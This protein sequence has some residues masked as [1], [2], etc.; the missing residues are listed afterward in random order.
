MWAGHA[1]VWPWPHFIDLGSLNLLSYGYGCMYIFFFAQ[2]VVVF[3]ITSIFFWILNIKKGYSLWTVLARYPAFVEDHSLV[4][5]LPRV[6]H[7]ALTYSEIKWK[8]ETPR[9]TKID[10]THLWLLSWWT[11]IKDFHQTLDIKIENLFGS[12]LSETTE[13]NCRIAYSSIFISA[14][15]EPSLIMPILFHGTEIPNMRLY[16]SS[17]PTL[18]AH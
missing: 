3:I 6:S 14:F 5:R 17:C 4:L 18:S 10:L 7:G 15:A 2:F 8:D 12:K 11:Q 1:Y 16:P 9:N 13:D